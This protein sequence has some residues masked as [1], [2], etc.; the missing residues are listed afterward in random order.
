MDH[1]WLYESGDAMESPSCQA[2]FRSSEKAL[3]FWT[4]SGL[5]FG[6]TYCEVGDWWHKMTRV[7]CDPL[8]VA[9]LQAELN[10]QLRLAGI[11]EVNVAVNSAYRQT[12]HEHGGSAESFLAERSTVE[13][14]E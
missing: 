1:V 5:P 4:R 9:V 13:K 2:V 10:K 7:S 8:D 3:T 6:E 11:K 12:G 14:P